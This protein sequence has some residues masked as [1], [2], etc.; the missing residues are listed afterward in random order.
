MALFA[1]LFGAKAVSANSLTLNVDNV[2][3]NSTSITGDATKGVSVIVRDTNKKVLAQSTADSVN[4]KFQVSLPNQLKANQKVYV[5]ARQ[6][7][8]S[9]FYRIITVKPVNSKVNVADKTTANKN[10]NAKKTATSSNKT[11][12]TTNNGIKVN[13]PTGTWKSGANAGYTVV[14]KF[15]QN[16]GLNQYLYYNGKF[17][18]KLINYAKYDVDANGSFWKITYTQRGQKKAQ[19]MYIRFTSN[20]SFWIVNSKNK[21]TKVKFGNAPVHYYRFALQK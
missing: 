3:T 11:T 16:T 18:K 17:V 10:S 20:K 1:L 6:S 14:T 15:S 13:T 8:N 9:Y 7:S 5:Y 4:G 21:A 2:Y 12:N 19:T